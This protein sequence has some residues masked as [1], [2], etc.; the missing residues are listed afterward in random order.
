MGE[1]NLGGPI[2]AGLGGPVVARLGLI[3]HG[4]EKQDGEGEEDWRTSVGEEA[5]T[6]ATY[7]HVG[8]QW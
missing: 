3:R 2:A 4:G 8:A 1:G 6:T 7:K 5:G